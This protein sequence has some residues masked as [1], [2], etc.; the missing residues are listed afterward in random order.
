M[1]QDPTCKI[2]VFT[3]PD[4][5]LVSILDMCESCTFSIETAGDLKTEDTP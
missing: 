1:R 2:Q 5:V 3:Y 4:T